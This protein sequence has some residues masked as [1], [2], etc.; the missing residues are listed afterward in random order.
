MRK[1]RQPRK[2]DKKQPRRISDWKIRADEGII[3]N[4]PSADPCEG[5]GP[6][7]KLVQNLS[8]GITCVCEEINHA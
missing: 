8:R 5:F 4:A 1:P 2:Y 7:P 6:A 3:G